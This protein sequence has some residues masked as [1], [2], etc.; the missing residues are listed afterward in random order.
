[1][2]RP[3]IGLSCYVE[4]ARWGAWDLPAA[5]VP[6]WYLELFQRA[7]DGGVVGMAFDI[8]KEGRRGKACAALIAFQL[9]HVDAVGRKAAHRFIECCGH[10][11]HLKD[12][13]GHDGAFIGHIG[14]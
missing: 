3:V 2:P 11:L 8:G 10:I 9:G 14:A 4:P 12:E 7:G 1:M 6:Q 13:G 5:L